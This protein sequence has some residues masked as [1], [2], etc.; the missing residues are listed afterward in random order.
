MKKV[1][2]IGAGVSGMTAAITAAQCGADVTLLEKEKRCGKKIL[3]TGNGHCNFSN[4]FLDASCYQSSDPTF[5]MQVMKRF[6]LSETLSFFYSL[7]ML[8]KEIDGRFYP[9]TGEAK[10]V[11]DLM[12]FSLRKEKV[13]VHCNTSAVKIQKKDGGFRIETG[14]GYTYQAD[15]LIIASGTMAGPKQTTA[16]TGFDLG[17]E[18]GHRVITPL[19][20]LVQL[21]SDN[22]LFKTAS[23]VRTK[24]ALTLCADG[25]PVQ[26]ETGELQITSYGIS[27]IP[28][29]QFSGMAAMHVNA[30]HKVTVSINFLPD[31]KKDMLM[32]RH[33]LLLEQAGERDVLSFQIG[34]LPEKLLSAILKASKIEERSPVSSISTEKWE[35]FYR[36]IRSYT[37]TITGTNSFTEAQVVRGGID[38]SEV[39][40][41]TMM[42]YIVPGL[43][44]CG[45]VLDVDGRCGGYNIQWAISS[46]KVAGSSA[47]KV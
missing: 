35:M 30:G 14:S 1:L 31:L 38:V 23:G 42:S 32:K 26:E 12:E 8:E 15:A 4:R 22:P 19:P 41:G 29:F 10:T 33:R 6:P 46:G 21:R 40:P 28:V 34:L 16:P 47:A 17:K 2:V 5:P 24:A 39:D 9:L 36:L 11:R 20:A 7:G 44:F 13:S 37:V 18:M 27:G 45:E 3:I 43:Y 25:K